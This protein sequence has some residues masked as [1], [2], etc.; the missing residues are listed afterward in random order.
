MELYKIAVDEYRFQV[1][2]NAQRSRDYFV[3]NSA[4]IASAVALLGQK[5]N[6]LAGTVFSAGL[7]VAVMTGVGFHTQHNYYR[8]TMAT[9]K[10]LEARL[11][12]REAVVRTTPSAGSKRW[13]F[14]SVT[15]F[16]YS[17]IIFLCIVNLCGALYSF[18]VLPLSTKK[19]LPGR[20][21]ARTSPN[22]SQQQRPIQP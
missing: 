20:P 21:A 8:E 2:L 7:L 17:I 19:P 22:S 12:I 4:I 10:L 3:L 18:S 9:K 1:N 13:R 5:V 15:Q 6:M 14:G 11:G 16:N